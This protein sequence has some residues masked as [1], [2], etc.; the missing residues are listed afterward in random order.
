MLQSV[1]K[2]I[3][4]TS[5]YWI[6]V[7]SENKGYDKKHLAG[8]DWVSGPFSTILAIEYYIKFLQ[9]ESNLDKSNFD[10]NTNT[11]KV[12]PNNSVE[13]LTFPFLT[14]EVVFNKTLDFEKID[15]YRGL[16][17]IHI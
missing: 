4:T 10:E 3:K 17:L 2:N 13:K 11:L 15:T 9:N 1:I 12:F 7:A 16:S 5:Y 6:S 14:G 8:E